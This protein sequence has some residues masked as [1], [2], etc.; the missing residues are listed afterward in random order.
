MYNVY[1]HPLSTFPGPSLWAAT[2]LP[3]IHQNVRG[4]SIFRIRQLHEQYG[5]VVRIAP[6]ELTFTD[7]RAWKDIYGHQTPEWPKS[8]D[9]HGHPT[10]TNNVHSILTVQSKADHARMRRQIA[11]AFSDKALRK[12][13]SL[14]QLHVGKLITQLRLQAAHGPMDL[15]AWYNYTTFDAIGGQSGL[16]SRRGRVKLTCAE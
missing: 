13:E 15:E 7:G 12:Q 3:L 2:R 16:M 10:P 14:L 4:T 6:D 8:T 9:G 5:P 11:H 1:L